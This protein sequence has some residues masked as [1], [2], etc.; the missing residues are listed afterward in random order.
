MKKSQ[1]QEY[2]GFD[3]EEMELISLVVKET[4]GKI[5]AIKDK[6]LNYEDVAYNRD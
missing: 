3:D 2:H 5:T 6:P 1:W 4:K